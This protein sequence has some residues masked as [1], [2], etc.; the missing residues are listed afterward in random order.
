MIYTLICLTRSL[1]QNFS[2][3]AP[4]PAPTPQYCL[5]GHNR[6]LNQKRYDTYINEDSTRQPDLLEKGH[7]P[8][9]LIK[10]R[11]QRTGRNIFLILY[12]DTTLLDS[13]IREH[14]RA[15]GEDM[16]WAIFMTKDNQVHHDTYVAE[17][18]T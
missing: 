14:I 12:E 17:R 11:T 9:Y 5:Q 6:W 7:N 2:I 18:T 4:A 15:R 3:P 16:R 8:T 10:E 1:N 13:I